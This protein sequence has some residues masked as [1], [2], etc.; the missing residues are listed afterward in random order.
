MA[1]TA[2][3][4]V[5]IVIVCN[6]QVPMLRP[7]QVWM[8][9]LLHTVVGISVLN[10]R[11][12]CSEVRIGFRQ[13]AFSWVPTVYCSKKAE[14]VGCLSNRHH[15]TESVLSKEMA[16]ESSDESISCPVLGAAQKLGP[17]SCNSCK[18]F[19]HLIWFR[20]LG[21]LQGGASFQYIHTSYTHVY[22]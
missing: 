5:V 18:G 7:I 13:L 10:V 12:F 11:V 6:S 3:A 8:L 17:P 21:L 20:V 19:Y 2:F 22:Q 15:R 14:F 4:L 16:R 9:L 1:I